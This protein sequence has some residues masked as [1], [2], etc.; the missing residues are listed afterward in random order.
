MSNHEKRSTNGEGVNIGETHTEIDM[1]K[2][3]TLL[4]CILFA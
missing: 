2:F 1:G 3:I 4:I